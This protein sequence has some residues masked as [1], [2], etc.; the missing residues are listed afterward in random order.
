MPAI[1]YFYAIF[2]VEVG[3]FFWVVFFQKNKAAMRNFAWSLAFLA[4]PIVI[5]FGYEFVKFMRPFEGWYIVNY[6]VFIASIAM[7]LVV[8][9]R[10]RS[11]G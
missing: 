10:A 11:L 3:V 2:I 9:L 5:V 8:F 4:A 1:F 7:P 6:L